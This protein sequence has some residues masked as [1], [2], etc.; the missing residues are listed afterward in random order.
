MNYTPYILRTF[1]L[2]IVENHFY[3]SYASL[4]N[5]NLRAALAKDAAMTPFLFRSLGHNRAAKES[6]EI[7]PSG[8]H[9]R[10]ASPFDTCVGRCDLNELLLATSSETL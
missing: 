4:E 3:I 1:L 8:P 5:N 2:T 10:K 7:N 9:R 6:R